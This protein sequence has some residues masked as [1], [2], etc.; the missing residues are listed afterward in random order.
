MLNPWRWVVSVM[1]LGTSS[2]SSDFTRCDSN[3]DCPDGY[4]CVSNSWFVESS[5]CRRLPTEAGD[6]CGGIAVI[7]PVCPGFT[8]CNGAGDE[9]TCQ[10]PAPGIPCGH[11]EDCFFSCENGNSLVNMICD[12]SAPQPTCIPPFS[13]GQGESCTLELGELMCSAGLQ[14]WQGTCTPMLAEGKPC[15]PGPCVAGSEACGLACASGLYCAASGHCESRM[16]E[17]GE[18]DENPETFEAP[19]VPCGAGL[20]CKNGQCAQLPGEE[21][22]CGSGGRCAEGLHCGG[23]SVYTCQSFSAEGE[24]CNVDGHVCRFDLYCDPEQRVCAPTAGVDEEC[25][26]DR[27]C[28]PSMYCDVTSEPAV[29]RPNP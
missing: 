9:P 23:T 22:P 3:A 5:A 2:C 27:P 14:C 13:K 6:P 8:V 29:C 11:W 16:P 20:F 26:C 4:V 7:G 28:L 10:F 15:P 12:V 21:E 25:G 17:G 18:C 19:F 24:P 1:I